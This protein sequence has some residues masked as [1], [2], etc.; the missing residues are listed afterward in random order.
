MKLP[1]DQKK[2]MGLM[3]QAAVQGFDE[4]RFIASCRDFYARLQAAARSSQ[5]A[6]T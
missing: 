6:Q 3:A 2:T 4:G 1:T 5:S